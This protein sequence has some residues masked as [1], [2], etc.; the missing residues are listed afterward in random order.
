MQNNAT[1]WSSSS[2]EV[3]AQVVTKNNAQFFPLAYSFSCC[4][5]TSISSSLRNQQNPDSPFSL[6]ATTEMPKQRCSFELSFTEL[7]LPADSTTSLEA[8]RIA[9]CHRNGKRYGATPAIPANTLSNKTG[10]QSVRFECGLYD[11]KCVQLLLLGGTARS[12]TA[13]SPGTPRTPR[14][15]LLTRSDSQMQWRELATAQLQLGQLAP[16]RAASGDVNNT[17]DST[18]L[19]STRGSSMDYPQPAASPS[20]GGRSPFLPAPPNAQD[21]ND[22]DAGSDSGQLFSTD[23]LAAAAASLAAQQHD[24]Q[25]QPFSPVSGVWSAGG[26]QV[27]RMTIQWTP[28]GGE[29]GGIPGMMEQEVG[30]GVRVQNA[31]CFVAEQRHVC[32]HNAFSPREHNTTLNAL[33]T[34]MPYPSSAAKNT[35]RLL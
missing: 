9:V 27:T 15:S 25:Q 31:R 14:G 16:S 13:D 26:S 3:L 6:Q 28:V 17:L 30:V 1:H 29:G 21:D 19:S 33:P 24:Q 18:P 20:P 34:P 12:T 4:S 11:G 7:S 5:P 35:H 22:D 8:F 23:S 32:E 10:P 2:T